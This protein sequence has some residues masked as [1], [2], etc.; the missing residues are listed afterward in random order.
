MNDRFEIPTNRLK[1]VV[2]QKSDKEIEP[3]FIPA[4]GL[5]LKGGA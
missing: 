1:G 4:L 3:Q 2:S 5:A